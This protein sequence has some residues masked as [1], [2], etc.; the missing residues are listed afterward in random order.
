MYAIDTKVNQNTNGL[1]THVEVEGVKRAALQIQIDQLKASEMASR[2]RAAA[3]QTDIIRRLER[4]EDG[5][6]RHI[7]STLKQHLESRS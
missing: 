4:I 3:R 1:K 2:L 6:N 5:V 7:E